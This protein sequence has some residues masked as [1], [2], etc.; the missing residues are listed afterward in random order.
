VSSP[1]ISQTANAATIVSID[2]APSLRNRNKGVS[3]WEVTLETPE[4]ID[5]KAHPSHFNH[6]SSDNNK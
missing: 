6:Q 1:A 4:Q 3:G 2:S 5:D